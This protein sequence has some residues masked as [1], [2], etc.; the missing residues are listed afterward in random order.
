[1]PRKDRTFR[2]SDV[3]RV[4]EKHLNECEQDKVKAYFALELFEDNVELLQKIVDLADKILNLINTLERIPIINK[5]MK[6][7]KVI[8]AAIELT[9]D[10]LEQALKIIQEILDYFQEKIKKGNCDK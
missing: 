1:M 2:H 5:L 8:L 10:L 9:K 6:Q 7:F 4:Y 3:I